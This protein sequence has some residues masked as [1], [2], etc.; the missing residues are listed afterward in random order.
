MGGASL[1]EFLIKRINRFIGPQNVARRRSHENVINTSL[2]AIGTAA[3]I[4]AIKR[5]ENLFIKKQYYQK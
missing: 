1:Y 5:F 2:G 4:A 3:C